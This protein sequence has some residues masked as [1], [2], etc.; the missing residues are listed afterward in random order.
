MIR[1]RARTHICLDAVAWG[2][3]DTLHLGA[4]FR[5]DRDLPCLPSRKE[6]HA[7]GLPLRV[8]NWTR[9]YEGHIMVH[10]THVP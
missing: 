9:M 7:L 8:H 1:C 2:L 10:N 5:L 6:V 4:A 3:V